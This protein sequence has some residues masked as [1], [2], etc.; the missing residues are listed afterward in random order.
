MV[1]KVRPRRGRS[2]ARVKLAIFV[3]LILAA[4]IAF[5]LEYPIGKPQ[6]Q[7]GMEIAAVYL[8]PVPMEP[9]GMMRGVAESDI[10]LEADFHAQ[11]DNRN[12]F[13]DGA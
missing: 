1:K 13:P 7:A 4:P 3:A 2:G 5:A 9:A 12:G 10:H 6:L 8:Q 11:H